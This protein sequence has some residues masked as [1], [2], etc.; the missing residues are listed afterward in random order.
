MRDPRKIMLSGTLEAPSLLERTEEVPCSE[1]SIFPPPVATVKTLQG[2]K[3]L[4]IVLSPTFSHNAWPT[5]LL[6][7][8]HLCYFAQLPRAYLCVKYVTL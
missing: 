5:S 8:V 6:F 3:T 7:S 4:S 1:D 2:P